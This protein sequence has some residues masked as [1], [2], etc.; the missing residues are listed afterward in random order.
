M[1]QTR[2]AQ[3]AAEFVLYTSIFMIV[4]IIAF[5][6]VNSQQNSE[7]PLQQNTVLKQTGQGF[8][9]AITLA[10][11]GGEGFS[12]RYVFPQTIYARPYQINFTQGQ[13]GEDDLLID[14]EGQYG[15]FSYVYPLPAYNYRITGNCISGRN[16]VSNKCTNVLLLNN[17]GN[18]LTIEQGE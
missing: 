11:K 18:T 16:L 2:R 15:N 6:V 1:V 10:I 3:V 12:Y 17:D 9:T 13:T 8:A 5:L 7:I 14:W 4:T